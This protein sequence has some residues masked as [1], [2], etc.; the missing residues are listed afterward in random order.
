LSAAARGAITGL[1]PR[2]IVYVSCNPT[3]FARDIRDFHAAG[4][5]PRRIVFIDMFPATMHI[6]A[7]GLLER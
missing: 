2:R 4:Y 3:T 6:E 1:K 5:T 7:I